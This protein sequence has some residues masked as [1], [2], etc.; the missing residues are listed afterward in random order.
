MLEH[1]HYG[2]RFWKVRAR[3]EETEMVAMAMR[4]AWVS[5]IPIVSDFPGA[6]HPPPGIRKL[7][8]EK[9]LGPRIVS[10]GVGWGDVMS[11]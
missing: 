5:G 6:L 11:Q 10:I 1:N 8:T 3:G 7:E 4:R 2:H 9:A